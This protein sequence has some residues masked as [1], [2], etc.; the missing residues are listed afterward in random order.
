MKKAALAIVVSLLVLVSTLL[1]IWTAGPESWGERTQYLVIFLLVAFG[2]FMAYRRLTSAR[3]GEPADDELSK[4]V[5]QKAAALS[6]FISIY[7]WLVIMYLTDKLKRETDV[8][9]GWG[10]LGMA[11]IFALSW[12][13]FNFRGIRNE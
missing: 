9:F 12:V 7:W 6:Y 4:K 10:I 11:I 2:F 1:W 13:F 8:M 3:R 5:V